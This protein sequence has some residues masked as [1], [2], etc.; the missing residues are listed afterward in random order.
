MSNNDTR[1]RRPAQHEVLLQQL[2]EEAGFPTMKDILLFAAG[3]GVT[4]NRRVSF[5]KSGEPIRYDT[6]TSDGW[7][8]PF[9]SMIAAVA[10]TGDPEVLEDARLGE[11]ISVFEEYANGGLEYIQEQVNVRK[12]SY[13]VVIQSL[14]LEALSDTQSAKPA[15][16]E[17]LLSSF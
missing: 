8:E 12:Q 10:A 11:R 9:I 3:V 15:S 1:V 13:E 5:D 2:K 14:V 16:I 7:S 4:Q 17:D 6:L